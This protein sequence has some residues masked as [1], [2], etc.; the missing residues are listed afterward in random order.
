MR[1]IGPAVTREK[2][3]AFLRNSNGRLDFPGPTQEAP[4]FDPW[5]EKFPWRRER[6]PTPVSWPR[7][8]QGVYS[9]W[10]CKESDVSEKL[11]FHSLG[12]SE[13]QG[14]LTYFSSWGRRV[15]HD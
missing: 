12:D 4:E 3:P 9:P 10:G 1:S 14:S 2:S 8:L 15:G 7:E 13:G 5:V 11:S 6:L